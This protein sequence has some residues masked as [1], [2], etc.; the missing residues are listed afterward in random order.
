MSAQMASGGV[1]A[2]T[3][4]IENKTVWGFRRVATGFHPEPCG[5]YR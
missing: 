2:L 1:I 4:V 3:C 5:L